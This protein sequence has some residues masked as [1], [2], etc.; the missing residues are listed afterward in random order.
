M[1]RY[2]RSACRYT[3]ACAVLLFPSL[4]LADGGM[5]LP[6]QG[7]AADLSQTRQEAVLAVHPDGTKV[8][9][10]LRSVYSGQASEFAWVLPVPATP[11]DVAAHPDSTLFLSLDQRTRPTFVI[12]PTSTGGGGCACSSVGDLGSAGAIV[13]VEASGKAGIFD[14]AAL[15]STGSGALLDW[16]NANGFAIPAT[17]APVLDG[18]VGQGMHFLAVR[19]REA[20]APA[21]GGQ[22]AIPPIQFTVETPRRF[23]PMTISQ[24]SSAGATEVILYVL[25]PHRQEAANLPNGLIDPS[26][27]VRDFASESYTNY[28]SLFAQKIADLGG[29][30]L[31]TEFASFAPDYVIPWPHVPA[32]LAGKLLFLTRMRTLIPRERMTQDF[33]FR[34]AADD[35]E[36]SNTFTVGPASQAGAAVGQ[37]LTALA[38][39]SLFCGLLRWSHRVGVAIRR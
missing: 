30:V 9:Y 15:T 32:D 3:S 31:I 20:V 4:L 19:V 37:S 18:Y 5:F 28:E 17:A 1:T 26:S 22:S 38:V 29:L 25:A 6:I 27:L 24:I 33:E 23:Y 34:D 7:E 14:W 36:V 12:A 21:S 35:T 2:R 11:T 8:T 13:Q 39:V 10:V 16:L